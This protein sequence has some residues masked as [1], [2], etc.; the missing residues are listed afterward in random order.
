[1]FDGNPYDRLQVLNGNKCTPIAGALTIDM[2]PSAGMIL[3]D[4]VRGGPGTKDPMPVE[5]EKGQV[6]LGPIEDGD[7][8]LFVFIE[9]LGPGAL[10]SVTMDFDN[11]SEW[12][13]WARVEVFGEHVKGTVARLEFNGALAEVEFNRFGQAKIQVEETCKDQESIN[14]EPTV[15]MM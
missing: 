7:Q 5:V 4:T 13:P 1:M 9:H 11:S 14:E 15:P 8:V 10:A 12:M 3:L 2:R 6:F